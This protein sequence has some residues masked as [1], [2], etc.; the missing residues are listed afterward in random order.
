MQVTEMMSRRRAN[1]DIKHTKEILKQGCST[2]KRGIWL[3]GLDG[4]YPVIRLVLWRVSTCSATLEM[5]LSI[6]RILMELAPFSSV[7]VG[8][9]PAQ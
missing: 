4:G 3:G 6:K 8:A 9:K 2:V 1:I 7:V 5:I